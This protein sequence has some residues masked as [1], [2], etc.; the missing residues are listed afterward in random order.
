[1]SSRLIS[2]S[3]SYITP[4]TQPLTCKLTILLFH[5]QAYRQWELSEISEIACYDW[6]IR[7]KLSRRRPESLSLFP[8]RVTFPP[9]SFPLDCS[10]DFSS[11][12]GAPSAGIKQ[13]AWN[14]SSW[15]PSLTV[16]WQLLSTARTRP[17][18]PHTCQHKYSNV[19]ALSRVSPSMMMTGHIACH[20]LCYGWSESA[21]H[22]YSA[23]T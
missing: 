4:T 8:P 17:T 19:K 1:M 16:T 22:Q 9:T 12:S 3:L 14:F 6:E 20:L 10:A 15:L 7:N 18:F 2:S 5:I 23:M 11:S 13:P 21:W